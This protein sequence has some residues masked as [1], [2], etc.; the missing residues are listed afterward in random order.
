LINVRV[1]AAWGNITYE[2]CGSA[3]QRIHEKVGEHT[4]PGGLILTC[5]LIGSRCSEKGHSTS[6]FCDFSFAWPVACGSAVGTV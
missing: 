1:D 4:G 3:F 5:T 6:D 2:V